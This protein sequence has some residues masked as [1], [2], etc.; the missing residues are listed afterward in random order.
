MSKIYKRVIVGSVILLLA[1]GVAY[2]WSSLP[3]PRRWERGYS[4]IKVG[5]AEQQVLDLMGK[6]SETQD[7]YRPRYSGNEEIFRK[8][9]E[10]YWYHGFM[11]D[12]F[13]VIGT[14]GKVIA[15]SHQVS[16]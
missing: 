12:W 5:D 3:H 7:C 10:E 1:I 14:N 8:C 9:A 6:P 15:K 4:E 16:P 11:E 2:A 13:I